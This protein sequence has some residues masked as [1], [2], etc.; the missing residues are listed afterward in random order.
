MI[1]ILGLAGS[2]LT[3][4]CRSNTPREVRT[5]CRKTSASAKCEDNGGDLP[6]VHESSTIGFSRHACYMVV[7]HRKYR[8]C[9][10][11]KRTCRPSIVCFSSTK[12]SRPSGNSCKILDA[13]TLYATSSHVVESTSTSFPTFG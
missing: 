11:K 2:R 9:S 5:M 8:L 6:I 1:P 3:M 12:P 4:T 10:L 13:G 7:F